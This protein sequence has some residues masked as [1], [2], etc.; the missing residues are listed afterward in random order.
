MNRSLRILALIA[1]VLSASCTLKT[2][3]RPG[4]AAFSRAEALFQAQ[5]YGS[6][7]EM[8]T[9]YLS[10][11]PDRHLAAD[12]MLRIGTIHLLQGRTAKARDVFISLIEAYPSS[13]RVPDARISILE[14]HYQ[15]GN[16]AEVFSGGT[17][18]LKT[19][20]SDN[21]RLKIFIL[22]ADTY[23]AAGASIEAVETY[24]MAYRHARNLGN[25]ERKKVRQRLATAVS[26]LSSMDIVSLLDRV[27]E[28][29]PRGFLL[30]QLG[31]NRAR[32]ERVG[33][34]ISH[35]SLFIETFP[36]HERVSQ[37]KY[38][39]AELEE[40][41]AHSRHTIG[42]LLPLSGRY[43]TFG[44]RALKG[45]ELA[46][47]H[48]NAQN[49][50]LP[51]RVIIEDTRSE[52]NGAVHAIRQLAKAKVAAI[53][54]PII[55]AEAAVSEAEKEEIP[56]IALSQKKDITAFGPYVFR[57]FMTPR[58]QVETIVSYATQT[59][60]LRT[61]AILYPEDNYGSTFV[62]LFWNDLIDKGGQVVAIESYSPTLMDFADVIKKLTGL[63]YPIPD[64]LKDNDY[65]F[66][67]IDASLVPFD[68]VFSYALKELIRQTSPPPDETDLPI[69]PFEE[70]DQDDEP[71]GPF[72]DFEAVF[73]PDA[74]KKAGL[75]IPQLAFY[76]IENIYLFGTN[77]W[78][79][80][81]M[82]DMAKEYVQGAILAEGFFAQ[83]R[84]EIVRG[85]VRRFEEIY[86]E[87]PSFIEAVAYD[88][89]MILF[90]TASKPTVFFR[91][92]LKDE[93]LKLRDFAGVTGLSSFDDTGDI[94]KQLYLLRIKGNDFVEV[95]P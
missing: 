12:A 53:I 54:G 6:A 9:R 5:S 66:V 40:K 65:R 58:M 67:H 39:L 55:T 31:E 1:V 44:D 27:G 50:D 32:E 74:P 30:Y 37:A 92:A 22:L 93:L 29:S 89:A 73:I 87:T 85:F 94:E 8:F 13:H 14:T 77:L 3:I 72:V 33:E 11:F 17:G 10:D 63:Y 62:D 7:L 57:N 78:H 91:Q 49:P 43:K 26:P 16:L 41:S 75:I 82:I 24:T 79:S 83:S 42:C 84:S 45:I 71:L 52:P 23:G 88:T 47:A 90:Q 19:L 81:R 28:G 21:H 64:D 38:L 25:P 4:D 95:T 46:L 76:D 48:F 86:G 70:E 18:L 35:L 20:A 34:A 69:I 60:G 15:E 68:P 51:I 2:M 36:A 80:D 61:F 59:L 56:I